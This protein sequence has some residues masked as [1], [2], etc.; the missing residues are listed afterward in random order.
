MRTLT[1]D[2]QFLASASAN[3]RPRPYSSYQGLY[4]GGG[5]KGLGLFRMYRIL[6]LA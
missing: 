3:I 2:V 4:I 5:F 6:G 1:P